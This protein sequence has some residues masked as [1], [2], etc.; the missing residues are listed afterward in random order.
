MN[1][2]PIYDAQ[3]SSPHW[4]TADDRVMGGVSIAKIAPDTRDGMA[5]YCLSGKVSLENRGGF[6]QMK[7]SFEPEM[8]ASQFTGV[9]VDVMG[10]NESY[11]VH[12]RT[13]QLWL[14]WQSFR[15]SL[16]AAPQWQQIY[17]PFSQFE[18]YSTFSTLNPE[19]IRKFA[20]VAIG[21]EF[22]ADVCVKGFG[23]YTAQ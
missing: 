7:W 23:F 19:G 2:H 6:V 13:R 11:N 21:R 14:P 10:N 1:H 22:N 12:I 17:L 9:Y 18:N 5:C 3:H 4:Q 20:I 8:D 15:A 16:T